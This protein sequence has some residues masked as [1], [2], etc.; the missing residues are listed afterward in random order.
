MKDPYIHVEKM[1]LPGFGSGA[2]RN[3]VT[4]VTGYT[5]DL[6]KTVATG[7]SRRRAIGQ[8]SLIPEKVTCLPCREYAARL[9]RETAAN[10]ESLLRASRTDPTVLGSLPPEYFAK[11]IQD[12]YEMAARYGTA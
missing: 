3:L 2:M 8:T 9:Y 10:T 7:C 12:D 4:R 6:P 5:S 1:I 11:S